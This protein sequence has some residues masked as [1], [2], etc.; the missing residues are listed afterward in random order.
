MIRPFRLAAFVIACHAVPLAAQEAAAD[1]EADATLPAIALTPTLMQRLLLGEIAAQRQQPGTAADIYLDLARSTRDPRIARRA[2]E[3]AVHARQYDKALDAT[4]LWIDIQPQDARARQALAHLLVATQRTEEL[5]QVLQR[6]LQSAGPAVG[7]VLLR[8]NRNLGRFNDKAAV[9]KIVDGLTTPYLTLAEARFARAQ[10][11]QAAGDA[12]RAMAEIDEAVALRPEWEMAALFKA[13]Q[14]PPGAAT[15]DYLADW[16]KRNP[17]AKDMRLAYARGLV[18]EKRYDEARAEFRALQASFPENADI[19][20]AIG[21]LALQLND[22]A[23]AKAHLQRVV[24][25]DSGRAETANF[26]LGQLAED[27]GQIDEAMRHYGAVGRGEQFVAAR[28]RGARLLVSQG[29]MLEARTWLKQG[30]EMSADD[31]PRLL[32]AEAH[33][34][35]EQGEGEEAYGV[36]LRG[37]ET[38]VDADELLYEAGINAERLGR[39]ADAERHFRRLITVKPDSAQGYNALGY[40]LVDRNERLDEAATL[41]DKALSLAPDDSYILDSKGWLLYRQGR[42]DEALGFLRRAYAVKPEPEVAAH[43][44]EVLWAQGK[45]SEAENVWREA[46][47][48]SPGNADLA[49]TI[50]RFLP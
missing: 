35:R 40:S 41:I 2:A 21:V 8:L 10:A 45:R 31:A 3:V 19:A 49:A 14:M 30:R 11:A 48:A 38:H 37:L 15:V 32:L 5:A 13:R 26:Y 17:T 12:M 20:F 18:G 16:I 4:R 36:L 39:L 7:E 6:E 42:L 29:R 9:W 23:E 25:L 43:I 33:L 28:A 34:L 47:K 46:D 50:K 1:T 24:T 44:G 27:A 22:T